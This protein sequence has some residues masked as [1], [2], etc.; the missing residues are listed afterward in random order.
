MDERM[1]EPCILGGTCIERW[2]VGEV[3]SAAKKQLSRLLILQSPALTT[4]FMTRCVGLVSKVVLACS[5]QAKAGVVFLRAYFFFQP[6]PPYPG[7]FHKMCNKVWTIED[8]SP[9]Y[10]Y[11]IGS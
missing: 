7:V 2:E 4:F 9:R 10:L 1:N 8:F 5:V 11:V 6:T 3:K